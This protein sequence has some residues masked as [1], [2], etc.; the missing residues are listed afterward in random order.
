MILRFDRYGDA[1]WL[2]ENC[3]Y[4]GRMSRYPVC[5]GT[6][7]LCD[8]TPAVAACVFGLPVTRWTEKGVIELNRL[9]RAPGVRLPPLSSLVAATV[10]QLR[11]QKNGVLAVSFA[12]SGHAHHGG[13]YQACSWRFH[14]K[15]RD[16][17]D[18]CTLDG[19]FFAGRTLNS[20]YG[21]RSPSKLAALL[22]GVSVAPH[23]S[24]GKYLYWLPLSREGAAAAERLGLRSNSYPKPTADLAEMLR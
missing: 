22:P 24:P 3:H 15:R 11:A 6:W 18:G 9:V 2:V 23:V 4:S 5:V 17:V 8:Q 1:K 16:A 21:T 19:V 7:H 10:R 20:R 13:V 14:E 12:D